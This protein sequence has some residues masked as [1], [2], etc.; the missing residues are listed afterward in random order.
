M[1]TLTRPITAAVNILKVVFGYLKSKIVPSG[2]KK[3]FKNKGDWPFI[4]VTYIP[5]KDLKIDPKYQRLINTSFINKAGSF[6]PKFVKPLSVFKRPDGDFVVVDGQHTSILAATYVKDAQDFKLPCQVQVHPENFNITQCEKA[7]AKYFKEFNTLRNTVSAVARLRADL[8]QGVEYAKKLE[9]Q[10][11][12]L[13]IHVELIGADDD[14]TNGVQGYDKLKVAL[15]KYGITYVR[16]AVDTYKRHI[17]NNAENNVWN[18]PLNGGMILG[19]AAAYSLH[20]N[21]GEGAKNQDFLSYLNNEINLTTVKEH[22]YQTAGPIMDILIVQKL[23][24]QYNDFAKLKNWTTIGPTVLND[25][26][27]DPAIHGKDKKKTPLSIEDII[28]E[29]D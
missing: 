25:W 3:E 12:S 19:L 6:K 23:V 20:D 17:A 7:E 5:L 10:F 18:K 11:K 29:L 9:R 13:N 21:L 27:T 1:A 26:I 4:P 24:K 14:A 16:N 2:E 28:E 15:A 8:A 22:T